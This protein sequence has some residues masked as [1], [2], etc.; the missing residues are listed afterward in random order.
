MLAWTNLA[1]TFLFNPATS[2][3]T[4]GPKLNSGRRDVNDTSVLLPGLTKIMEIGGH[5]STGTT[6]TAEILDLSASPLAWNL[7]LRQSHTI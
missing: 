4:T 6:A 7:R 2:A 5:T 1:T 3:W